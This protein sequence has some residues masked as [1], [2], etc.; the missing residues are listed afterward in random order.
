[1]GKDLEVLGKAGGE[2]AAVLD[3]GEG[4]AADEAGAQGFGEDV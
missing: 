2:F 3:L 4:E 1:M